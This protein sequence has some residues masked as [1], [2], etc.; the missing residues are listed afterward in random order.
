MKEKNQW[1]DFVRETVTL[2]KRTAL[3]RYF[4]PPTVV[5]FMYEML[6]SMM[7]PPLRFMQVVGKGDIFKGNS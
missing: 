5:E 4:T 7:P 6:W 3:R 2:E 1:P